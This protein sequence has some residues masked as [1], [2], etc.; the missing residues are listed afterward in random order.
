MKKPATGMYFLLFGALLTICLPIAALAADEPPLSAAAGLTTDNFTL[1]L[2]IGVPSGLISAL[3]TLI[4]VFL[5]NRTAQKNNREK[6]T[7]EAENI[8]RQLN[9]R[10]HEFEIQT[11]MQIESLHSEEKKK[12][13]ADF[14]SN[15]SLPF[16]QKSTFDSDK[17]HS[18]IP[19]LYLYCPKEYLSYFINLILFIKRNK[20]SN[21]GKKYRQLLKGINELKREI[22]IH[23][24]QTNQDGVFSTDDSPLLAQQLEDKSRQRGKIRDLWKEYSKHYGLALDAAQKLIWNEPIAMAQP[25]QLEDLPDEDDI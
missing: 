13:C 21:S 12:I 1:I 3:L 23:E 2:K 7:A 16:F 17:M 10:Q 22:T 6:I 19:L 14:L 5:S 18:S 25:L 9:Q 4:G 15:V 8:S 24:S 20:M 11:K